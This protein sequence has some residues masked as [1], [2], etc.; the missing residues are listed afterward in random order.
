MDSISYVDK[1]IFLVVDLY[2]FYKHALN[3]ERDDIFFV[4]L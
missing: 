1:I 3:F 2:V 4:D